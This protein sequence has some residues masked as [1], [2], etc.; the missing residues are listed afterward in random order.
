MCHVSPLRCIVRREPHRPIDPVYAYLRQKIAS[1]LTVMRDC[2]VLWPMA[3]M[4]RNVS[5]GWD[6][7]EEALLGHIA[8]TMKVPQRAIR[9]YSVLRRALD[10]RRSG[11]INWVYHVG[12]QVDG[13]EETILK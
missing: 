2:C 13:D 5:L 9:S 1:G 7:P 11:T 4:V 6:E 12:V 8:R 3:L 10:A